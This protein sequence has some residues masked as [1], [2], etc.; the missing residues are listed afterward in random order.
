M[1]RPRVT[2]RAA[3]PVMPMGS[4]PAPPWS[5]PPD[6]ARSWFARSVGEQEPAMP[7]PIFTRHG[8]AQTAMP[9]LAIGNGGERFTINTG[10]LTFSTG[11]TARHTANRPAAEPRQACDQLRYLVALL[12]SE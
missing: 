10:D 8:D 12:G 4:A 6:Q 9:F 11:N 5:L 1:P 3:G 7:A 2:I